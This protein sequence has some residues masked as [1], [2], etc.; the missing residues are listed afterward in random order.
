MEQLLSGGSLRSPQAARV[1]DMAPYLPATEEGL[2]AG[3]RQV[4]AIMER[5]LQ[6]PL[7]QD[8]QVLPQPEAAPPALDGNSRLPALIPQL[9][10]T[11]APP[12]GL[13]ASGGNEHLVVDDVRHGPRDELAAGEFREKERCSRNLTWSVSPPRA[14][15]I[16]A[17]SPTAIIPSHT[18]QGLINLLRFKYF[19]RHDGRF[20]RI[21]F[22]V[23]SKRVFQ[24]NEKNRKLKYNLCRCCSN[25]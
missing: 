16:E 19:F 14:I 4:E 20:K 21:H 6:P 17:V 25:N 13:N 3:G 2:N 23:C 24:T 5:F 18:R 9:P 12:V 1:V 22:F 10:G 8:P 11:V 15:A 7:K